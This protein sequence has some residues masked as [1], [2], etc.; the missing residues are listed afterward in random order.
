MSVCAL[1]FLSQSFWWSENPCLPLLNELGPAEVGVSLPMFFILIFASG[2]ISSGSLSSS[3]SK[4][5]AGFLVCKSGAASFGLVAPSLMEIGGFL[6]ILMLGLGILGG[7]G[8]LW[9]SSVLPGRFPRPPPPL[10]P[11]PPGLLETV[12]LFPTFG[13]S[14]APA[15]GETTYQGER[16]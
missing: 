8:W 7:A 3:S 15:G 9:S 10:S 12:L 13:F 14:S 11:P 2:G 5:D 1:S 16:L 4:T 6:A